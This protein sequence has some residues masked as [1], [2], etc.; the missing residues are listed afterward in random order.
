MA[1]DSRGHVIQPEQA[2]FPRLGILG[3]FGVKKPP[4]EIISQSFHAQ[5]TQRR[6]GNP[7]RFCMKRAAA[8]IQSGLLFSGG[9]ARCRPDPDV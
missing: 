6:T 4:G 5:R 1:A 3:D 8:F 7:G 2:F 9:Q